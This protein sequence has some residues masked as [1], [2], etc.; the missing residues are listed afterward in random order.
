MIFCLNFQL[1]KALS[2]AAHYLESGLDEIAEDPYLLALVS[3]ALE[4][5]GS[6]KREQSYTKLKDLATQSGW[7]C[8]LM[9]I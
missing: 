5:A 3:Y 8:L 1:S 4:L 6:D 7:F 2:A 9:I